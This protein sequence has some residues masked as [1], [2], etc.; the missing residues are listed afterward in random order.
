MSKAKA[1]PTRRANQNQES[2]SVQIPAKL[3]GQNSK[4]LSDKKAID[5]LDKALREYF[6]DPN[7]YPMPRRFEE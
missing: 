1:K 7:D 4:S 2:L 3:S 6:G 5:L